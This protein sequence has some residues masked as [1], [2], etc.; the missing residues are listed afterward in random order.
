MVEMEGESGGVP[1]KNKYLCKFNN[2]WTE[3]CNVLSRSHVNN[4]TPFVKCVA[5]I[6]ISDTVGK[7]HISAYYITAVHSCSRGTKGQH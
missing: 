6:L 3:E 7:C 4:A 5:L 1:A 2:S